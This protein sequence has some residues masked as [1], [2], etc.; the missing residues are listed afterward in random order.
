MRVRDAGLVL[1]LLLGTA[2]CGKELVV[3]G[4]KEVE[5]H[6]TGDGTPEGAASASRAPA[7][8]LAPAGGPLAT[9]IAGRA[10][11]TVTFDATVEV[12]AAP[13]GAQP[14]GGSAGEV[15][16]LDGH[17]TTLVARV[18]VPE[19]SYTAVRVTFTRVTANVTS[20]LVIGGI[21]LTGQVNVAAP[22]GGIVVERPVSLGGPEE[23]V[24]VLI[25]LDASAWLLAATPA[26][27]VVAAT[28]FQNAVKI[29][30][31]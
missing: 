31:F 19:G 30:T 28:A 5:T 20:G 16:R 24:R 3:G 6:A 10:Q 17:D 22:A 1:L 27:R 9:H 26:T 8:A 12:I 11:G 2:G 13:G 18:R 29:R 4:Q 15:V 7:L 25:D 14:A 23:D 21:N